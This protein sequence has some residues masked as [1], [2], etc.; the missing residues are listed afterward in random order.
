MFHFEN[1]IKRG[2]TLY[3]VQSIECPHMF[4]QRHMKQSKEERKNMKRKKTGK[5]QL[6]SNLYVYIE[7]AVE[8]RSTTDDQ[9][10]SSNIRYAF[11]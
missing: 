8:K 7:I 1:K 10:Q 6:Y 5:T 11:H 9:L 4:Y 2:P 3:A